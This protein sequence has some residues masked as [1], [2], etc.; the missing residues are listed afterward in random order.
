MALASFI[1]L[2]FYS[3][4]IRA[5][6]YPLYMTWDSAVG[7]QVSSN[8]DRKSYSQL[9]EDH[10][11]L[12]VCQGSTVVYSLEAYN[13]SW[14]NIIWNVAGGD[15]I[16][17]GLSSCQVRW[18]NSALSGS[19]G[20]TVITATGEIVLPS[21]CI[22]FIKKPKAR[23]AK[24]PFD[25][26][27]FD[28]L[29]P[30]AAIAACRNEVINFANGSIDNGGTSL[31]DYY[32]EFGDGTISTAFS[33]SHSYE[34]SGEYDVVL[35]VTNACNCQHKYTRKVKVGSKGITITC[36]GVVCENQ[37][38]TYR[39]EENVVGAS[40]SPESTTCGQWTVFGGTIVSPSTGANHIEVDWKRKGN[41]L[42]INDGFGYVTFNPV[43][44]VV[45]CYEPATIK[46]PIISEKMPI[47]GDPIVCGASQ[48]RYTMPQWPTTDFEWEIIDTNAT[49]NATIVFTDQR[50]EILLN[51]GTVAGV[52]TLRVVYQNTLLNCGGSSELT[53]TLKS[54]AV[55]EGATE[56]CV[57]TTEGYSLL[58]GL[59]GNWKLKKLPSGPTSLFNGTHFDTTFTTAGNYSLTVNGTSFCAASTLLITVKSSV[60]PLDVEI[61]RDPY[62][63]PSSPSFFSIVNTVP[64]TVIGWEVPLNV[65]TIVGPAY[66]DEVQVVFSHPIPFN[67]QYAI[68]VWRENAN[69]P[70]CKSA[71]LTVPLFVEE[72]AIAPIHGM[73]LPCGSTFQNYYVVETTGE[74]YEWSVYPVDAGSIVANGSSTVRVL[75][76]QFSAPKQASLRLTVT[77]CNIP[78]SSE[79]A[80]L[81]TNP[82]LE[83]VAPQG[84]L[85]RDIP[86]EFTVNATPALS[87]ITSGPVTWDFGDGTPVQTGT[88]VSHIYNDISTIPL[89]YT[90]SVSVA[91]PNEC[92][93]TITD[94]EIVT[95]AV[96]PAAFITPALV[97]ACTPEEIAVPLTVNILPGYGTLSSIVW[98]T[99][100]GVAITPPQT[101]TTTYTPSTYGTY[102]AIVTN[103]N[104]ATTTNLVVVSSCTTGCVVSPAPVL[105]VTT[106][107]D[108]GKVTVTGSYAPLFPVPQ[109]ISWSSDQVSPISCSSASA[110]CAVFNF[111]TPGEHLVKYTLGYLVDGLPCAV[112][113]TKVAL[114]PYIAKVGYTITCGSGSTYTV[115]LLDQ[116]LFYAGTPIENWEFFVNGVVQPQMSTDIADQR[117]ISL[118]PGTY[119]V[120]LNIAGSGYPACYEEIPLVLPALPDAVFDFENN[121]CVGKATH[122]TTVNQPGVSYSWSFGD[123][124]INLQQ[125]PDREYAFGGL[126]VVT[127][128]VTNQYGCYRETINTVFTRGNNQGGKIETPLFGCPGAVTSL[129]FDSSESPITVTSYQWLYNNTPIP[130]ATTNP[131]TA[132]LASGSYA[133]EVGN[134][135]GCT[136][137][138]N[139]SVAVAVVRPAIS[140]I[141]GPHTLCLGDPIT[142]SVTPGAT[143]QLTYQ[144]SLFGQMIGTERTVT[145][146][147]DLAGTYT[148]VLQITTPVAGGGSCVNSLEHEVTVTEPP[149]LLSLYA[150]ISCNPYYVKLHVT[151]NDS[152]VFNW[153]NG[154][155]G[156]DIIEYHGGVFEVAFTNSSGCIV[157]D[158]LTVPQSPENYM[159]IFPYGCYTFCEDTKAIRTLIGPSIDV[160][161]NWQWQKNDIIVLQNEISPNEVLPYTLQSTSGTIPNGTGIYNLVLQAEGQPHEC[162]LKSQDMKV[163]MTLCECTISGELRGTLHYFT[164]PFNHY[165]FQLF[166]DNPFATDITAFVTANNS[167]GLLVP[168]SVIVHQ[169]GE[170]F[171]FTLIPS[172]TYIGES[173]V[174]FIDATTNEGAMCH[175]HIDIPNGGSGVQPRL[176]D[177]AL[178]TMS[179][180]VIPNPVK[181][182]V[183]LAFDYGLEKFTATP[184]I[185][186][187]DLL[188][189]ELEHYVPQSPK[190]SW[191]LN[192]SSYQAGQYIVVMRLNGKIVQ[193]KNLM[194]T[195]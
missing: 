31:T 51:P 146:T 19:I 36:P 86:Y 143:T 76:N 188:G 7:C 6:N 50:N 68:K 58:D 190:E 79:L 124:T 60:M 67:A 88:T 112:T 138:I 104:C 66:G 183:Q 192:M 80:I 16:D 115:T 63:C 62:V 98:Y 105:T 77:K 101:I 53:I 23:F 130:G 185:A 13:P 40:S 91:H 114:V 42:N 133:I 97:V 25:F 116:S 9:I 150:D 43:G 54:D 103:E 181:N 117:T 119:T 166:I 135:N 180:V 142:L 100:L 109:N 182:E 167:V 89:D 92:L 38:S 10:E 120:R 189:R 131:Y 21:L 123:D 165:E 2:F 85:C 3:P 47:V 15:V 83:I 95:L 44:C 73:E 41:Q 14:Q 90:I 56:T 164:L 149:L 147:P 69:D 155:T 71:V 48:Q 29:D 75:W 162:E 139:K 144:W 129:V 175:G 179:L 127:L 18:N 26:A 163:K 121:V 132:L 11:C 39:I 93:E 107:N 169:G 193:Q 161:E 152:G 37:H 172:D 145:H 78:R 17:T 99:N 171:T 157:K 8:P 74:I 84:P 12:R 134:I 184:S 151:A 24:A 110:N 5:Q 94:T 55:I 122:F 96:S 49:T 125:N 126:H 27:F 32:W 187:Y 128:R 28:M 52:I 118:A 87:P 173:F 136:H 34:T 140:T 160:F 30:D 191:Y 65:G 111:Y 70:I 158:H 64:N 159:W 170:V 35:T 106:T 108:C 59:S 148:Y 176:S 81:I 57:G 194:L 82:H 168:S 61:I 137:R 153:S 156:S 46:I 20:A 45:A 72:L 1:F 195:H 102:Y 154:Q 33:P 186:V 174:V 177:I 4:T 178:N 113:K 22:D 141:N